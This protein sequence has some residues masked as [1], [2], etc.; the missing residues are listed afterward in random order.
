MRLEPERHRA[1]GKNL[2]AHG[3][4][5]ERLGETGEKGFHQSVRAKLSL[6]Q[7]PIRQS[8]ISSCLELAHAPGDPP[9]MASIRVHTA[10]QKSADSETLPQIDTGR[11]REFAVAGLSVFG[12][13]PLGIR[14]RTCFTWSEA[15]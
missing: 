6:T 15:M 4:Q 14:T 3:F 8:A 12:T 13:D 2:A 11:Y 10:S 9:S 5:A 7:A 1:P